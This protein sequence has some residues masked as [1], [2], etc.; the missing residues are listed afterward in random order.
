MARDLPLRD[1]WLLLLGALVMG[2]LAAELLGAVEDVPASPPMSSPT[3]GEWPG[4]PRGR[5]QAVG[6]GA[7]PAGLL[8]AATGMMASLE[9]WRGAAFSENVL[10]SVVGHDPAGRWGYYDAERHELRVVGDRGGVLGAMTVVHELSHALQDQHLAL[11]ARAVPPEASD[12]GMA[13]RALVEGEAMLAGAELTGVPLDGHGDL[14]SQRRLDDEAA[15]SLFL[16]MDGAAFVSALR[17]AGGWEAVDAAWARPPRT[18]AEILAPARYLAAHE[19]VASVTLGPGERAGAF[20]L[21]RL[22]SHTAEGR[23]E[24]RA[25]AAAWRGDALGACSP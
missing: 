16:Y 4:R 18:T 25:I 6:S 22:L 14:P 21:W 13:W 24:G 9:D 8:Q 12:A 3:L 20:A 11:G 19:P 10:I 5:T 2:A 1:L 23:G 15:V 17:E 7:L